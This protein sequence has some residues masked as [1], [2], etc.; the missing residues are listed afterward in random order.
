MPITC[1][2]FYKNDYLFTGGTD[3]LKV[4][5][6]KNEF[7]LTDNIETSSK[8][9]LHMVVEDKVQQIAFSGGSLTYH[10]CFLSEVNFK[11]PYTY[12]NHSI[13]Y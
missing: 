4:W 1:V 3:N 6:V 12:S 5:D 13:S 8:G 10:Q 2:S 9:I 11:G 7:C